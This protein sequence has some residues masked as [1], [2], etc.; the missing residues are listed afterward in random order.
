LRLLLLRHAKSDWTGSEKVEDHERPL[1]GR[2]RK[3]APRIGAC[4]RVRNYTPAFVLCSTAVRTRETLELILPA[5]KSTPRIQY[6]KKLYLADWPQ[7]L[8]AVQNCP[9]K[10]SP[11]LVVGHNP[12][13]E[14]LAL[15][16]ALKP[17][18]IAEKGRA[19]KLAQK[20]PTA[21]LAVFDFDLKNWK[22]I[23]PGQGRL[24]DFVRPKDLIREGEEV[25][26]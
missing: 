14:Q 26:E 10:V 16:L 15:A 9:G 11:L 6:D 1:N 23:K 22:E 12:G 2:G 21:A 5:L 20:F 13:L 18:S 19:Q 24:V 3:T 4:L 8:S 7:L 25:E 17:Q